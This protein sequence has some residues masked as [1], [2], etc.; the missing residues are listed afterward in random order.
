MIL[1]IVRKSF[2]VHWKVNREFLAALGAEVALESLSSCENPL[3]K[4]PQSFGFRN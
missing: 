4:T 3:L 2:I 1:T